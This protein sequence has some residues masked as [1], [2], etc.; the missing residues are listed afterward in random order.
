MTNN[1]VKL[2]AYRLKFS[3]SR[4]VFNYLLTNKIYLQCIDMLMVLFRTTLDTAVSSG[5]LGMKR[6]VEESIHNT[7]MSSIYIVQKN[8]PALPKI[9]YLA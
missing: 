4:H 6:K 5:S 3:H 7:A 8:G 9:A 1:Y 2:A